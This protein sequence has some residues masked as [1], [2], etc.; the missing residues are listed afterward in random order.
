MILSLSPKLSLFFIQLLENNKYAVAKRRRIKRVLIDLK[1]MDEYGAFIDPN[2]RYS[3]K[4]RRSV[5]DESD[6]ESAE[7]SCSEEVAESEPSSEAS[8]Y[9]GNLFGDQWVA[10]DT[11]MI[12]IKERERVDSY[13]PEKE[14]YKYEEPSEPKRKQPAFLFDI[15]LREEVEE[16]KEETSDALSK[17]AYAKR[18]S[19]QTRGTVHVHCKLKNQYTY[20][21]TYMYM[22][23]L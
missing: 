18:Q 6:E 2:N 3:P 23:M 4:Q 22:Y 13:V 7:E 14:D 15:E 17:A 21:Y 10:N 12:N 11:V 5:Y 19:Q 1:L 8:D 9:Y 16:E 20:T